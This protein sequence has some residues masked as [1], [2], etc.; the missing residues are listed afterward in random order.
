[1]KLVLGYLLS[2]FLILTIVTCKSNPKGGAALGIN[3]YGRYFVKD[4]KPFFWQ[5]DTDWELFRV[6][7]VPEAKAILEKRKEQGFSVIQVMGTG[8]FPEAAGIVKMKPIPGIEAWRDSNPLTPNEKYFSRMD[9]IVK[10]AEELDM[11]LAV[12]GLSCLGPGQRQDY[13]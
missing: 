13:Y 2:C 10:I 12:G 6:Y 4:G 7:T 5:G 11:V 3:K 1:M 9:S 8:V